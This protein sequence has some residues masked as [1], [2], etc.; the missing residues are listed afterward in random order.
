MRGP[1]SHLG[2]GLCL[3]PE[4]MTADESTMVYYGVIILFGND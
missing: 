3:V 2:G 4:R 1:M